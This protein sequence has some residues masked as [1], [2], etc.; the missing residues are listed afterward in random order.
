MSIEP[1]GGRARSYSG[2]CPSR[3]EFIGADMKNMVRGNTVRSHAI[4]Q[5][6]VLIFCGGALLASSIPAPANA[7]SDNART[8]Q[9]R[10]QLTTNVLSGSQKTDASIVGANILPANNGSVRY[11]CSPSGFGHKSVC[12]P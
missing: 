2:A 9:M 1:G 12:R 3:G 8:G 7:Q 10:F 5:N 6:L 4:A 11:V